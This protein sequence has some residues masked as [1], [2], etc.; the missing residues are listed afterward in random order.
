MRYR[1]YKFHLAKEDLFITPDNRLKSRDT[2]PA[3]Y[4]DLVDSTPLALF[5]V[6]DLEVNRGAARLSTRKVVRSQCRLRHYCLLRSG[7]ILRLYCRQP[8]SWCHGG[9]WGFFSLRHP[10]FF[11]AIHLYHESSRACNAR[12]IVKTIARFL[13]TLHGIRLWTDSPESN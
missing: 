13:L 4:L 8:F 10:A 5:T 12:V 2:L 9:E 11:I 1:C 6:E 7:I 3:V